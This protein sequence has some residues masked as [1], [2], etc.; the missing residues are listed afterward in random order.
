MQ[1]I[2]VNLGMCYLPNYEN[3]RS[4]ALAI[5]DALSEYSSTTLYTSESEYTIDIERED[6]CAYLTFTNQ[7]NVIIESL[8]VWKPGLES[9]WISYVQHYYQL[10]RNQM[11][12]GV[13][14]IEAK[15]TIVPWCATITHRG[16][17]SL[18]FVECLTLG[19]IEETLVW[20]IIRKHGE[21]SQSLVC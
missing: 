7:G 20:A 1:H 16:F 8:V 17:G 15:P 18:A 21:N 11:A 10:N 3:C 5:L 9:R 12:P 19:E 13:V 14:D 6:G 2:F 4:E